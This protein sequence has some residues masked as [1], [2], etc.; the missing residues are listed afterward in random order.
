MTEFDDETPVYFDAVLKPNRSLSQPGFTIFMCVLAVL[1]FMSGMAFLSLGAFPIIGFFGLDV[2]AIWIAFKLCFRYQ[3]Q[4]TR[5]RVTA[6]N[7]RV[8]HMNPKGET[9]FIELPSAFAR[10]ELSE[11]LTPY[12]WLTLAYQRQAYVIGRFLTVDERKSLADAIR[13]ALLK[14]RSER[15]FDP[16]PA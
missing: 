14:A 7:L 16:D 15:H 8:D 10:I 1:S 3:R 2:L 11:P 4:W 12:S 13:T 6:E 5:V 9:S